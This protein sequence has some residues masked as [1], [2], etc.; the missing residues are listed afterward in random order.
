MYTPGEKLLPPT[1]PPSRTHF[2]PVV[3]FFDRR[4]P[5]FLGLGVT[6]QLLTLLFRRVLKPLLV[7]SLV[8]VSARG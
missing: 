2:Y 3:Y 8:S 4:L 5:W 1:L 7:C 6:T